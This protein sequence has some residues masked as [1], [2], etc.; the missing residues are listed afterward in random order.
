MKKQL[1]MA[2][3]GYAILLGSL[4][5]QTKDHASA[6]PITIE[7]LKMNV[8]YVGV[9]NPFQV[10]CPGLSSSEYRVE[11]DRGTLKNIGVGKY[12]L[13]VDT[14]GEVW[15]SI[16]TKEKSPYISYRYRV[17]RIPDP[18]PALGGRYTRSDT[19]PTSQF[20]AQMGVAA[21]LENID[22]D[23]KCDM[24]EYNITHIGAD[25]VEGKLFKHRV[26]NMGARYSP[27]SQ[28]LIN[29]AVPGDIFIFSDIKTKCPGDNQPRTLAPL[30]F[31]ME[32]IQD[33]K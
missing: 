12:S 21:I 18:V 4:A 27:E 5:A 22:F 32:D 13:M 16:S 25:N 15:I 9:E 23:T 3:F 30:V 19:M 24:V 2:L 33:D 17:K 26:K 1:I 7:L 31:F 11:A 28:A 10:N 29:E 20:K 6:T 8:M 14:P